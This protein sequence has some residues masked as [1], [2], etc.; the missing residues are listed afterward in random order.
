[1][2]NGL[3]LTFGDI[4]SFMALLGTIGYN[5]GSIMSSLGLPGAICLVRA[6][7]SAGKK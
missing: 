6:F 4:G 5:F 1:M 2:Q 3:V 7:L